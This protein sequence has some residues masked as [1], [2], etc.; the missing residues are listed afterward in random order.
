MRMASYGAIRLLRHAVLARPHIWSLH[1]VH[2]LDFKH[3]NQPDDITVENA[4][5]SPVRIRLN[6]WEV[7]QMTELMKRF[8]LDEE[9]LTTVEYALLLV[10]IVIAGVTAWTTLGGSVSTKVGEVNN[11]ISG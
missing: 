1:T 10:L 7:Y 11:T 3:D 9:G 6:D 8:W 5:I 4:G 2:A